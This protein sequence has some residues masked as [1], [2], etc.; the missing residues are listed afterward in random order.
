M[1]RRAILIGAA[2]LA[3]C[4]DRPAAPPVVESTAAPEPAPAIEGL[5]ALWW[6]ADDS[7]ERM[8][9]V[10][11]R[12]VEP[13]LPV[14]AALRERWRA[15]GL[16]LVRVPIDRLPEIERELPPIAPRYRR[17]IGWTAEWSEV[18]RGRR[19]AASKW[20]V[21][22][23]PR[24]FPAGVTRVL[25]RCWPV[26]RPGR[27]GEFVHLDIGVQFE[28]ETNPT[29]A[30][31]FAAPT[32]SREEDRGEVIRELLLAEEIEAGFAYV[33]TCE[34]PAATWRES[35]KQTEEE[36]GFSPESIEPPAKSPPPRRVGPQPAAAPT[37]GEASLQFESESDPPRRLR[38]IIVLTIRAKEGFR[39]LR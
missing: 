24:E 38:S 7:D 18:F 5:E 8:G 28:R 2:L 33:I 12:F 1:R 27:A 26:P 4:A 19:L 9:S 17:P 10:L 39:L 29:T 32:I 13:A 11:A 21:A 37:L 34:A 30:D 36:T 20:S 15:S 25:T 31:P 16:R 6:L 14:D 23:A 35:T 3:G 22:G